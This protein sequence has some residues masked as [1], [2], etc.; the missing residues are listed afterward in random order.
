MKRILRAVCFA[1]LVLYPSSL[2]IAADGLAPAESLSSPS[3]VSEELAVRPRH[4]SDQP[5]RPQSFKESLDQVTLTV[6]WVA[7]TLLA[8]G[9]VAMVGLT[10]VLLGATALAALIPILA[11]HPVATGVVAA[12]TLAAVLARWLRKDSGGEGSPEDP[13]SP[14]GETAGSPGPHAGLDRDRAVGRPGGIARRGGADAGRADPLA[15]GAARE[16]VHEPEFPGAQSACA[17]DAPDGIQG[18]PSFGCLD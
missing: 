10:G 14:G 6:L 15:R 12:G 13:G 8:V 2:V 7:G 11:A 4:A 1:L 9:L 5:G 3:T 18:F 17:E 16:L